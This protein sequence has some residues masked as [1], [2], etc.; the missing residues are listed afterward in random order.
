MDG[1]FSESYVSFKVR[2]LA[3]LLTTYELNTARYIRHLFE[4]FGIIGEIFGWIFAEKK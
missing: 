2:N 4:V 3:A 1:T